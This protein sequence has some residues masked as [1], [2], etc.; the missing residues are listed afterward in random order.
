M[1]NKHYSNIRASECAFSDISKYLIEEGCVF[2]G[3]T[4]VW[5]VSA[6][7]LRTKENRRLNRELGINSINYIG[8]TNGCKK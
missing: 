5:F 2:T 4:D 1:G 6:E 8:N 7:S 3:Y